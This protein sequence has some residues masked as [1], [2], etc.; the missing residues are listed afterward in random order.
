MRREEGGRRE[1]GGRRREKGG[2]RR[3]KG[4]RRREEGGGRR[5]E[6]GGRRKEVKELRKVVLPSGRL[7]LNRESLSCRGQLVQERV[8]LKTLIKIAPVHLPYVRG[9]SLGESS[10]MLH[11]KWK[12]I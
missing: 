3:E 10:F 5:R 8:D 2:R 4:G 7:H 11:S 12:E 6:G 9:N 1:K